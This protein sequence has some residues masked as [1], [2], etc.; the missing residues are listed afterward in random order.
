[1]DFRS[2]AESQIATLNKE[3]IKS[4]SKI[5]QLEETTHEVQATQRQ[6]STSNLLLKK[7]LDETQVKLEDT[8]N[9]LAGM[10]SE[11][12]A[13]QSKLSDSKLE[14][15]KTKELLSEMMENVV[16]LEGEKADTQENMT[17]LRKVMRQTEKTLTKLTSEQTSLQTLITASEHE[18]CASK[19]KVNELTRTVSKL[20]K[21]KEES[22]S[23]AADLNS[24]I[25]ILVKAC[26]IKEG[27]L[28]T[29]YKLMEDM[30]RE[31]YQLSSS[32]AKLQGSADSQQKVMY[33]QISKME[34][35]IR[36]LTQQS[37]KLTERNATTDASLEAERLKN[38]ELA[39]I[40]AALQEA[41]KQLTMELEQAT[42]IYQGLR[43]SYFQLVGVLE[44][45][46]EKQLREVDLS[47]EE[48]ESEYK[49]HKPFM[50]E[51]TSS[52]ESGIASLSSSHISHE[53]SPFSR[54][55]VHLTSKKSLNAAKVRG[56]VLMLQQQLSKAQSS[57][58]F[59]NMD[60]CLAR[61][62]SSEFQLQNAQL[63]EKV[64]TLQT[65]L[66]QSNSQLEVM[67]ETNEQLEMS[68][69]DQEAEVSK[70]MRKIRDLGR[71]TEQ[72]QEKLEEAQLVG[73]AAD[74]KLR[75]YM[76]N[77][78]STE[79][80]KRDLQ[81]RLEEK[82]LQEKLTADEVDELKRENQLLRKQEERKDGS[83]MSMEDQ[84]QAVHDLEMKVTIYS[85]I[86]YLLNFLQCSI[87][88]VCC[89]KKYHIC[90]QRIPFITTW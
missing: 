19:M 90:L 53:L 13:L 9:A 60:L 57:K 55:A 44:V 51:P 27:E 88:C 77:L 32:L 86:L 5:A 64:R 79:A 14:T 16:K 12:V 54:A 29:S 75:R 42:A 17:K 2:D 23:S 50:Y 71:E 1:M 20:E 38:E 89:R 62:Q 76:D 69:S 78:L 87:Y 28:A 33:D 37:D 40:N 22:R 3:L 48:R 49:T 11:N 81:K 47:E 15:Q 18:I 66:A 24:R 73:Q 67:M 63:E 26:E 34:E 43:S 70:L 82:E 72:A 8:A 21:E 25:K 83:G 45:T 59:A 30:R 36:D 58:Q 85:A 74:A 39:T 56:A 4:A 68:C 31:R 61:K 6:A 80:K 84:F 52:P 35:H 46:L 7:H 41:K 65:V 10:E